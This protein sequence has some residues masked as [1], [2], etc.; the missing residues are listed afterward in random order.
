VEWPFLK[1]MMEKRFQAKIVQLIMRCVTT[2]RY[3]LKFNEIMTDE[4][5][6]GRSLLQGILKFIE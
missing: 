1:R 4:V 5:I 3:L 6:L 2:V